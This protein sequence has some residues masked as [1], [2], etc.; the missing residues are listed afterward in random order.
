MRPTK[1]KD[2]VPNDTTQGYGFV[3]IETLHKMFISITPMLV[4]MGEAD[5]SF[6]K[7]KTLVLS[8][9]KGKRKR[10]V[11]V[12]KNIAWST[13][14][15]SIWDKFHKKPWAWFLHTR[16]QFFLVRKNKIGG[17][18]ACQLQAMV[19]LLNFQIDHVA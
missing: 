3:K 17:T 19:K 14:S 5:K 12:Y 2:D 8:I 11:E 18:I 16:C 13:F 7:H 15:I 6:T 1:Q 10:K 4:F 9:K